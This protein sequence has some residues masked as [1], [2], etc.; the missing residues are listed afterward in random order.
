MTA[1]LERVETKLWGAGTVKDAIIDAYRVL[2]ATERRPRPGKLKAA[3][4]DTAIEWADVNGQGGRY[5]MPVPR[6]APSSFRISCMMNV[7]VETRTI[8][9]RT[10]FGGWFEG[11][12]RGDPECREFLMLSSI[13]RSRKVSEREICRAKGWNL[14]TFQRGRDKGAVIVADYLNRIGVSAWL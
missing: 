5:K 12:I 9:G 14:S 13:A 7:L 10:I 1:T 8:E 3:W 2:D 6:I 4:P 11:P